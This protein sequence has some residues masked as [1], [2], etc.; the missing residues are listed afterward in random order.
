M[1][2]RSTRGR[3]CL[4]PGMVLAEML[5]AAGGPD[6]ESRK[7]FWKA[8]H[9]EPP[10]LP[11]SIWRPILLTALSTE[12]KDRYES[13]SALA[14]ALEE[15]AFRIEG[16]EDRTP[17]PGL[18]SFGEAD[19]EFFFGREAEVEAVW[20]KLGQAQMLA[21]VG[22][23]GSGKSSFVRAGLLP[24][25]P[26]GWGYLVCQPGP[27]PFA[28]LGRAV[29][30]ESDGESPGANP[31]QLLAAIGDWRQRHDEVLLILD[32]FEELFTQNDVEVQARFADLLR[33]IAID[34]DVH[35][36]LSMRD[37]FLLACQAHS[38]LAPI[39]SELTPLGPPT[40][41]ALRRSLVQPALACGYRL[42]DEVMVEDMLAEVTKERGALPL[43]AFT[44]ARL[45][46]ERDRETGY[47]TRAAY[48]E[49]GGVGGALAQH[50][51]RTLDGLGR[52]GQGVV[53][54][55]FRNLVTPQGTRASRERG[56]LLS[57]FE[58][59]A[60]AAAVLQALID[61]RLLTAYEVQAGDDQAPVQRVEIIHES[62]L[63]AWPRLAGWMTQDADSARL[64]D[65]LRQAAKAWEERQR[66]AEL[67]WTGA[68]YRE[69][70]VWRGELP[71]RPHRHRRGLCQGD[72]GAGQPEAPPASADRRRCVYRSARRT[73]RDRQ[74]LAGGSQRGESL[75]SKQAH[76]PGS[77][78]AGDRSERCP[79]LRASESRTVRH[80]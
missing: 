12:P 57:V 49:M 74:L 34:K 15:V 16:A 46:E 62:L 10:E 64:R 11:E 27:A 8:A 69:F 70:L 23:S 33:T 65:Q 55:L 21:I 71:G 45:W 50:A 29:S 73:S 13:A 41:G 80:A 19:A 30:S 4:P 36:L 72:A 32:Q 6:Q 17:Y 5:S 56:A 79:G 37:D 51:E 42:E 22:A 66:P 59:E 43:I 67:L 20:K 26:E 40:G 14:R 53:R 44:A 28:V 75:R 9:Q 25:R 61:A 1:V 38:A 2:R 7:T 3:T 78:R 68:P 76:R 24:V 39:F 18:A 54:E 47:L 58:D 52:E 77:G 48:E 35:L 63:A 31:D 60:G